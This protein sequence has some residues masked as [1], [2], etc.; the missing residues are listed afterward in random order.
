MATPSR[1]FVFNVD[2]EEVQFSFAVENM[3][4]RS[5]RCFHEPSI[6]PLRRFACVSQLA[7]AYEE[8][9]SGNLVVLRYSP[10]E[11]CSGIWIKTPQQ[12]KGGFCSWKDCK[13]LKKRVENPG[14]WE[15]LPNGQ[16]AGIRKLKAT[17]G[18]QID[19]R[20]GLR[21]RKRRDLELYNDKIFEDWELWT[22]STSSETSGRV[23]PLFQ[24]SDTSG[25]LFVSNIGP[26]SP[27]GESSLAFAFGNVLKIVTL[28][29]AGNPESENTEPPQD[30]FWKGGTRRGR[31]VASGRARAWS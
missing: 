15:L 9:S 7:F 20:K 16:V 28:S 22:T 13:V 6:K 30:T 24:D 1:I 4:P 14:V 3:R 12:S 2:L 23:Q 17:G 10:S 11:D 19:I 5:L 29:T 27:A 25:H 26:R 18:T 31:L 8:A 21:H